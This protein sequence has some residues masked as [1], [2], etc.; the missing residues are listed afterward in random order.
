MI[1]RAYNPRASQLIIVT[2]KE[3]IDIENSGFGNADNIESYII[4]ENTVAFIS[5]NFHLDYASLLMID[6]RDIP[7][8]NSYGYVET[9][10]YLDNITDEYPDFFDQGTQEQFRILERYY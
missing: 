1:K 6:I 3:T 8:P 9:D 7:S 2:D 5:T 4:N 10:V